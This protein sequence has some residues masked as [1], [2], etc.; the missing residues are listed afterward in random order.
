MTDR[1]QGS[2]SALGKVS[3]FAGLSP[4][5]TALLHG[6]FEERAVRA[7]TAL[8]E[9]GR[10]GREMFVLVSGRVRVVK[11]MLL[12]GLEAEALSGQET[13][14]VLAVLDGAGRPFFGEMSLVSDAPRSATVEVLEE[15]RFL[16]AD[17]ERFYALVESRPE[18]GVKL[19]GALCA[20]MA[21]MVRSSNAQVVK[22]TTALAL[23]LSRRA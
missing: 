22:L 20:R 18:L 2:H 12:P 7:G 15:S 21:E 9:E 6:V 19:L 11:S 16:V 1:P 10:P 13:S 3:L 8:I 14:K 5:E 23:F 4:E 17:R